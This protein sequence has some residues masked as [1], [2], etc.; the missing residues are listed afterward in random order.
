MQNKTF[1]ILSKIL[2][3]IISVAL[4]F[5]LSC[6]FIYIVKEANH[7]CDGENCL[8]CLSIK[9]CEDNISI[10]TGSTVHLSRFVVIIFFVL[11]CPI[12][13]KNDILINTLIIQKVRLND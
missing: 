10:K 11:L 4:I 3:V 6:S 13:S 1:R 8:I 7:N 5:I 12:P 2:A 9:Q